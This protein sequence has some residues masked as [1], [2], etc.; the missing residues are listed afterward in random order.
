MMW[1][2]RS[3]GDESKG[4]DVTSY[5]ASQSLDMRTSEQAS[6]R[7]HEPTSEI[8]GRFPRDA[9]ARE[10]YKGGGTRAGSD[11]RPRFDAR[12]MGREGGNGDV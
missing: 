10:I 9:R 2:G 11:S 8:A 1:V 6:Q 4:K 3:A 7:L 12:V 5:Q